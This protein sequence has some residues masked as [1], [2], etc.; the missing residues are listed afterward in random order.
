ML[1]ANDDDM[2]EQAE[3]KKEM[4]QAPESGIKKNKEQ[5]NTIG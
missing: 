1:S 2:K 4:I 5:D 3:K